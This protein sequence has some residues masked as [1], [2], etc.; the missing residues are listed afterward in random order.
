M[1]WRKKNK[2]KSTKII[3]RVVLFLNADAH[4]S[5]GM[6]VYVASRSE[7]LLEGKSTKF[8][9]ST[10]LIDIVVDIVGKQKRRELCNLKV[11]TMLKSLKWADDREV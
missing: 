4:M 11:E 5:R 2:Q 7:A 8:T 1:L 9:L 3:R 10:L 6:N